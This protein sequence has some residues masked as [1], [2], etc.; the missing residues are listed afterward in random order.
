M[1][2]PPSATDAG[3]MNTHARPSTAR[4]LRAGGVVAPACPHPIYRLLPPCD[5]QTPSQLSRV[6]GR[7]L[8]VDGRTPPH[9]A[10][11]DRIEGAGRAVRDPLGPAPDPPPAD[12]RTRAR[13]SPGAPR[14]PVDRHRGGIRTGS[15]PVVT[16]F[17][18]LDTLPISLDTAP[19]A[20]LTRCAAALM[21]ASAPPGGSRAV[22]HSPHR[23]S[24]QARSALH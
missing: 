6:G 9:R 5:H 19:H 22:H 10:A 23:C 16:R 13:S 20:R 15:G 8:S 3:L 18:A 14:Y 17:G 4:P 7:R 24:G 12:P 2:S 1:T 21:P 11:G